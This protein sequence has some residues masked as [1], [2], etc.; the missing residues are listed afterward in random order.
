MVERGDYKGKQ[1][2]ILK[3]DA[4]DRFPLIFGVSK[5]K[6]VL[7][8]VS[9]I[10]NFVEKDGK[11]FKITHIPK[12]RSKPGAEQPIIHRPGL[13]TLP[14]FSSID[15]DLIARLIALKPYCLGC[16]L[17]DGPRTEESISLARAEAEK[18]L[19]SDSP[20]ILTHRLLFILII[21]EL[22][23]SGNPMP[24]R[25]KAAKIGSKL[26]ELGRPDPFTYYM[27]I[28]D[29][30]TASASSGSFGDFTTSR[31]SANKASELIESLAHDVLELSVSKLS[32]QEKKFLFGY[33]VSDL[34]KDCGL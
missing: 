19:D 4:A 15:H 16:E 20:E 5:A 3:R 17:P 33:T 1:T 34:V 24:S 31:G 14:V 26:K 23:R 10:K 32:V 13:L 11:G 28:V 29:H 18:R 21:A 9:E 8:N 2:I 6:L 25:K 27:K 7:D 22:T 30:T 12:K